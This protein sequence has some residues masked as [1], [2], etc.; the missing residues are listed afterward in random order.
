MGVAGSGKTTV[1]KQLALR[2][3]WEFLDGDDYHPPENI[4]KMSRGI[5]LTDADRA[6]W[7]DRLAVLI[8]ECLQQ[9]RPVVLAC[10][11]LKQSYRD[12]LTVSPGQVR[13]VYLKGSH[14]LIGSRLLERAGHF[15][16][17]GLLE[18]QFKDL[19]EPGNALEV[20]IRLP[21]EV[22]AERI[23]TNLDIHR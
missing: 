1:G 16:P 18:S 6:G 19:E 14:E 12:R 10:S 21:V 22:I 5:P 15:M 8:T 2:L 7:L 9:G 13:F 4:E 3:D 17:P 20:D 23:I 11:A